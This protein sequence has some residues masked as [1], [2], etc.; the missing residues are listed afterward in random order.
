MKTVEFL[1]FKNGAISDKRVLINLPTSCPKCGQKVQSTSDKTGLI[2]PCIHF[3]MWSK[4]WSER[5][6]GLDSP[7]IDPLD[8]SKL[9]WQEMWCLKASTRVKIA[10]RKNC[11]GKEIRTSENKMYMESYCDHFRSWSD[12]WE[13]KLA[14]LKTET[15]APC[16]KCHEFR[17]KYIGQ[18]CCIEI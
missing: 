13:N 16:S 14:I 15:A 1:C 3:N 17:H 2:G 12:I 18:I 5:I 4:A 8:I 6:T 11:C 9:E 10:I 7:K